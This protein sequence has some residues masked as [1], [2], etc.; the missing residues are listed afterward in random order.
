MRLKDAMF[1]REITQY[2][3]Y[4]MTGIDQSRISYIEGGY[5]SPGE[6]EKQ[7]IE[8]AIGIKIDWYDFRRKQFRIPA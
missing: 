7:K 4:R 3:L 2:D 8:E 6:D 1:V 5:I